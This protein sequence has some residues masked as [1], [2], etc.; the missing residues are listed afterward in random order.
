ML[1][2]DVLD[3]VARVAGILVR[4]RDEMTYFIRTRGRRSKH[5][6]FELNDLTNIELMSHEALLSSYWVWK[7]HRPGFFIYVVMQEAGNLSS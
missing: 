3:A 7:F 2:G 5:P 4:S 6:W 1:F